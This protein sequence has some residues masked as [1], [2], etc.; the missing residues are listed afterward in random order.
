MMRSIV[1]RPTTKPVT[2]VKWCDERL[3]QQA[4]ART[5][6][7]DHRRRQ[8]VR[9]HTPRRSLAPSRSRTRGSCSSDTPRTSCTPRA[10]RTGTRAS[11]GERIFILDSDGRHARDDIWNFDAVLDTGAD[12]VFGR[13]RERQETVKRLGARGS[14]GPYL[15]A[16]RYPLHDV[17]CGFCIGP[18]VR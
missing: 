12:I 11:H 1:L 16:L 7:Q 2:S 3:T 10:G 18:G 9:R 4:A 17:N 15:V 6:I 8:C 14:S 5:R 13:R